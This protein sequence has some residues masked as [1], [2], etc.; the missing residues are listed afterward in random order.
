MSV[1]WKRRASHWWSTCTSPPVF[2]YA[3]TCHSR[4]LS[5]CSENQYH[6]RRSTT[7][8]I[9]QTIRWTPR[10]VRRRRQE[11][12]YSKAGGLVRVDHERFPG[13]LWLDACRR[14]SVA[15]S[16]CW[17]NLP[18][19]HEQTTVFFVFSRGRFTDVEP[20]AEQAERGQ[21]VSFFAYVRKFM[22]MC[23]CACRLYNLSVIWTRT[24]NAT[25]YDQVVWLFFLGLL[26]RHECVCIHQFSCYIYAL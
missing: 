10:A 7:V 4:C 3:K 25:A 23:S 13:L 24:W 2:D 9:L 26:R 22:S 17:R 12:A 6:C 16:C 21:L 1:K 5:C 14:P 15:R 18:L 19:P 20:A 11:L 8:L